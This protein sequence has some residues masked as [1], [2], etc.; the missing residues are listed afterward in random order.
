MRRKFWPLKAVGILAIVAVVFSA[1]S[2]VVM[3][4]WNNV[5]AVVV[6]V[7]VV[8]FWQ[9]AGILVLSKILFGGFKGGGFRGGMHGHSQ[10]KS[11]M[12]NKWQNVREKWDNMSPEEREK[13]KQEWK[14]QCRGRWRPGFERESP[15]P[16]TEDEKPGV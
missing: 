5:L 13:F 16:K 15:F 4:L 3:Q 9:A 1:L 2:Y 10:W 7:G 14:N 6:H 12:R 8:T 11:E